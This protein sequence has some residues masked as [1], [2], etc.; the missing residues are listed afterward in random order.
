MEDAGFMEIRGAVVFDQAL[1]CRIVAEDGEEGIMVYEERFGLWSGRRNYRLPI[2]RS[3]GD[4]VVGRV[5]IHTAIML[6]S[7][8]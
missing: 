2:T 4:S 1:E 8:D 6:H 5:A 3:I 7:V